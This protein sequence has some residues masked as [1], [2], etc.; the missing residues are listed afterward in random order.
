MMPGMCWGSIGRKGVSVRRPDGFLRGG[1][2]VVLT[3][4]G[5]LGWGASAF[6][7]SQT[8][9]PSGGSEQPFKVPAGVT[10]IEVTAVGGAGQPGSDCAPGAV[11]AGG[12]GAK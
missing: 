12:L 2:V 7:S 10:Q 8:F 9:I 3:V 5:V 4:V 11:G 6:A 1:A